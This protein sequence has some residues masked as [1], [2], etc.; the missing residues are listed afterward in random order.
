ML[1]LNTLRIALATLLGVVVSSIPTTVIAEGEPPNVILIVLDDFGS[2]QFAPLALDIVLEDVDPGLV[3][4]SQALGDD[5]YD[6]E[7]ALN[8]AQNAMPFM[9]TLVSESAL[10]TNAYAASSLCAPSR[11]AI[12]TGTSPTRWGAYRN[13][14]INVC[15]FPENRSLP[16]ILQ[17][18]GYS[19][20][21][22]GK[23]HV[24]SKDQSIRK[25]ILANGGTEKD[26]IEAGYMGSVVERDHPLNNGFDYAFFYNLWE[27]PYYDSTH[28]WE[29]RT[30]TGKQ[31]EYNTDLFTD[32]GLAFIKDALEAGDPF[33]LEIAY[34]SV[35]IPLNVDAPE[36]YQ[37]YITTGDRSVDQFYTHVYAIDHSI[38]RIVDTLKDHR[39]WDNTILFF[40][41]DNG[42]TCKVGDGDLSL[43]PGNLRRQGHKG[44]YFLGGVQ[45]PL[46]VSWP[47]RFGS[48]QRIDRMVSL[49][50][51]LPT[52][53]DAAGLELPNNIDGKSLV[54]LLEDDQAPHHHQLFF[55]GIQA[56]AWGYTGKGVIGNAQKR[57][58]Q[59]P[60]AW[61]VIQ[62]DWILRYVGEL[63]QGLTYSNPT[64][65][66]SSLSLHNLEDDPLE[67]DNRIEQF[68]ELTSEMQKH[69][70]AFAETLPPPHRWSKKR[71][72]ELV[73][74][75]NPDK[76]IASAN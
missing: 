68:P 31:P 41:S 25:R 49:M 62:D 17:H 53:I 9:D 37:G 27:C 26:A 19:T 57:R 12:L 14:D 65:K 18:D 75:S 69:Y 1:G 50:D 48:G 2:G 66:P 30:H 20:G 71:W 13:I 32:K 4:Y 73:P 29:N 36:K 35:H 72:N 43:V 34:H 21:F 47:A 58:D 5:S 46:V 74:D 38:K 22:V 42:A 63:D 24:G 39:A 67:I 64:G 3:A 11:Q 44:Q 70:D 59:F 10:F 23:W 51:L 6:A 28:L 60:G 76:A 54:G 7:A 52:A 33:F 61:A 56:P 15:G 8:A 40:T 45:V 55:A 16:A